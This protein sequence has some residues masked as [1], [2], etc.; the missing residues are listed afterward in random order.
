MSLGVAALVLAWLGFPSAPDPADAPLGRGEKPDHDLAPTN[1][2]VIAR[3]RA[4]GA[5]ALES[6]AGLPLNASQEALDRWKLE[7]VPALLDRIKRYHGGSD[8]ESLET[9]LMALS[10]A[11]KHTTDPGAAA[12]TA[13]VVRDSR[14]SLPLRIQ[15]L[16]QMVLA[17]TNRVLAQI[18]DIYHVAEEEPVREAVL[19][20]LPQIQA[21]YRISP[22]REDL[23]PGL[24]AAF[25]AEPDT[26]PLLGPLALVTAGFGSEAGITFLLNQ[27]FSK[28]MTLEEI[29]G[30]QDARLDVSLKALRQ[31]YRVEAV[32]PLA[33]LLASYDPAD[34]QMHLAGQLLARIADP[35]ATETLV[36]Y[37]SRAP[38]GLAGILSAWLQNGNLN[39]TASGE[40][41][42]ANIL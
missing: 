10:F 37:A 6:L 12:I 20:L 25:E 30:S 35:S 31:V 5:T 34:P 16:H 2:P 36:N 4:A 21:E 28:Q 8:E 9:A 17:G 40:L 27:I 1:R 39:T 15:I 42:G 29:E 3:P 7:P 32:R 11:L 14:E 23:T 38:A 24:V 18:L 41:D 13:A 26:S 19:Q 22:E 33:K